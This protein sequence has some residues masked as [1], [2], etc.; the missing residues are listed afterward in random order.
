MTPPTTPP[1]GP[2]TA[3]PTAAPAAAPPAAPTPVPTGCEPGAPVM[4]SGLV[5]RSRTSSRSGSGRV[6]VYSVAMI[7]SP[8]ERVRTT[9]AWQRRC[10]VVVAARVA[11][12]S[13]GLAC[14]RWLRPVEQSCGLTP[15]CRTDTTKS[16]SKHE[17]TDP[18]LE[19][20]RAQIDRIDEQL[21]NLLNE[22]AKIVVEIGKLKQLSNAP[23]YAPDREKA[24]LEKIWRLNKGPLPNRC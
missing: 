22:R 3:V 12:N 15:Y 9:Q 2:P 7:G 10:Q 20:L 23:I 21:V 17:S 18:A 19:A 1:T 16:M 5:S 24:V 14:A 4:G 6:L 13:H 8:F 11:S